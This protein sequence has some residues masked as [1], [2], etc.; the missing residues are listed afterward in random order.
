MDHRVSQLRGRISIRSGPRADLTTPSGSRAEVPFLGYACAAVARPFFDMEA[1][2]AR[3]SR[4]GQC[5]SSLKKPVLT[6][7]YGMIMEC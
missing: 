2:V 5:S 1:C 7:L 4:V 6:V 3:M